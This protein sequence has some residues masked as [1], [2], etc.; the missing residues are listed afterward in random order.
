MKTHWRRCAIPVKC[1]L[2]GSGAGGFA[3]P[4]APLAQTGRGPA[5]IVMQKFRFFVSAFEKVQKR[6][7]FFR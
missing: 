6:A 2:S 5:G 7:S 1:L 4:P 3:E